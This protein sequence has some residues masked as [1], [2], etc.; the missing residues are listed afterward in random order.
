MNTHPKRGART[1]PGRFVAKRRSI[2][3]RHFRRA[4]STSENR[5]AVREA[6]EALDDVVMLLCEAEEVIVAK[7]GEELERPLLVRKAL[8]VLERHVEEAALLAFQSIVEPAVDRAF[9][10]RQREMIGRELLRMAAEHVAG[11]LVEQDDGRQ[12]RQR[13][14]ED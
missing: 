5:V 7:R 9:R 12:R 4:R 1:L 2:T 8:A 13:V 14:V 6:P 3:R 10:D 11:E